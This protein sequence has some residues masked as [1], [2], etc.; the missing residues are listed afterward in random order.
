MCMNT[1]SLA[2]ST[3]LKLCGAVRNWDLARH[4]GIINWSQLQCEFTATCSS[5]MWASRVPLPWVQCGIIT[6]TSSPLAGTHETR[7]QN[8]PSFLK[9][10]FLRYYSTVVKSLIAKSGAK[11]LPQHLRS[12]W[13]LQRPG[14]QFSA[15]TGWLIT[16]CSSSK[17]SR[18]TSGV[19]T[20]K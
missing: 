5:K 6:L 11:E 2:S 12:L 14:V 13:P 15:T 1:C 3:V 17:G 4:F 20:S 18:N 9:L 10:L 19:Q 8:K 16:F 7:A